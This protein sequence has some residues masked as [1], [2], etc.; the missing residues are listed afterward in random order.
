[1]KKQTNTRLRLV[2]KKDTIRM[3][4]EK[5]LTEAAGG[6]GGDDTKTFDSGCPACGNP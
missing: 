6:S 2:L 4:D 3:L 1:M 5:Q